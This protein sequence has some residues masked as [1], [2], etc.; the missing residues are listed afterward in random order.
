M[1]PLPGQ[2]TVADGNGAVLGALT[3]GVSALQLRVGAGASAA[4]ST[5]CS[6]ACSWILVPVLLQAGA[7][8]LAA[9]ESVLA[10][11]HGFDDDAAGPAIGRSRC[12]PVDRR[13]DRRAVRLHRRR[14]GGR[15]GRRVP[16]P[17]CAPSPWTDSALHNLGASASWGTGRRH[18][19]RRRLP[20]P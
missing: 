2:S 15:Q 8:Y 17:G 9:A 1:F 6:K 14:R 12:R 4:S 20:A 16:R 3:G 7:D 13:A 11:I 10:L 5:A 19:R 18:R